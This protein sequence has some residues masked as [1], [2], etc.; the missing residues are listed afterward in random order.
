MMPLIG[1]P[2]M[3]P[4]QDPRIARPGGP[5]G[6]PAR[7][8]PIAN[9]I[10]PIEGRPAPYQPIGTPNVPIGTPAPF[11][12]ILGQFHKGGKVRKDGAYVLKA[13]EHVVPRGKRKMSERKP[14]KMVSVAVL[15][16]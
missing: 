10:G 4:V 1:R 3:P 6:I 13:G 15:K 12:P 11:R 7:P 5:V 9:P 8:Q 14:Q 2:M 16:A